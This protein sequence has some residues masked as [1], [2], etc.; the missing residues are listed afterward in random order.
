[1]KKIH[2]NFSI[3]IL[4][5]SSSYY[6]PSI[7]C[8][9]IQIFIS[10]N[11]FHFS[12]LSLFPTIFYFFF[13]WYWRKKQNFFKISDKKMNTALTFTASSISCDSISLII[14]FCCKRERKAKI[15]LLW[16]TFL[17]NL[18]T[19]RNENQSTQKED[20]NMSQE[21]AI[22][23]RLWKIFSHLVFMYSFLLCKGID[24]LEMGKI[25]EII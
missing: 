3:A 9:S 8:I 22:S 20:G 14:F 5:S 4:Y 16:P 2:F 17:S 19:T 6:L 11:F 24:C 25:S 12:L 15:L 18:K 23:F 21:N 10:K 1:V 13:L 7:P